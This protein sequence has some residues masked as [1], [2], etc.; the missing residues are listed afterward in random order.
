MIAFAR[1]GGEIRQAR[2]RHIHAERAGTAA[3]VRHPLTGRR[4][5][6]VRAHQLFVQQLGIDV[7]HHR[8]GTQ[9][10]AVGGHHADRTAL[11][12]QHFAHAGP[13]AQ[14]RAGRARGAGHRL[15]D[16]AHAADG[17]A[18]GA[19]DPVHLA[20]HMMQQ[21]VGRTGCIRTGVVA[22]HAVETEQRLHRLAL[23]PAVQVLAGR[24]G[25]QIQQFLAQ[26]FVQRM[27]PAPQARG[28]QQFRQRLP[29]TA[30][31]QVGGWLQRQRAQHVG[32]RIEAG[33]VGRQPLGVAGRE[34]G[35]FGAG[36]AAA[37]QQVA[38]FGQRQEVVATTLDHPQAVAGQIQI[39]NDPRLQQRD[40]IGGDR[41][42]EAGMELFGDR[43]PAQHPA[44]FQHGHL[45]SG[46]RQVGGAG[47]AIVAPANQQDIPNGLAHAPSPASS[48]ERKRGPAPATAGRQARL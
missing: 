8:A 22:D 41:I 13:G 45:Q 7:G 14:F 46:P 48:A 1:Q 33:L 3:P 34:P 44:P 23:E 26:G 30:I 24:D 43:R 6:I 21:H 5:H 20:E 29:P 17:V 2:Q 16:R 39:G 37:G 25:E 35:E 10:F 15:G 28:A 11:L 42:A 4:G 18:P 38:T 12:D 36:L 47:Q 40:R 19:L 31:G 9:G 32:N 27:Q